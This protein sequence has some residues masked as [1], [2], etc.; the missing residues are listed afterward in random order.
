MGSYAVLR[1]YKNDRHTQ[2][3]GW[4][5]GSIKNIR[6]RARQCLDVANRNPNHAAYVVWW[7][8]HNGHNQAWFID[9]AGLKIEKYPFPD[10]QQFR[11]FTKMESKR[12]VYHNEALNKEE[13]LLRLRTP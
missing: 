7:E 1:E 10:G 9:T 2:K 8:C 3:L 13:F 12:V 4:F 6:N 5:S 11:I